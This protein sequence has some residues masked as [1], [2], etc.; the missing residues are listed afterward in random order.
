[1]EPQN[2]LL[3]KYIPNTVNF[4]TEH[5]NEHGFVTKESPWIPASLYNEPWR[6]LIQFLRCGGS[7]EYLHRNPASRRR[8]QKG[9][10]ESDTVKYVR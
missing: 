5:F 8:R 6:L 4:S 7:V 1:M 3:G 10:L 2:P 9:N